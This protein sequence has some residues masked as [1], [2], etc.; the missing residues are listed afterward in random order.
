VVRGNFS[1]FEHH[2]AAP[3]LGEY[4][5]EAE[6]AGPQ[7]TKRAERIAKFHNLQENSV[8]QRS[9]I[10]KAP[11]LRQ[12]KTV[13]QPID[14]TGRDDSG[15]GCPR[16]NAASTALQGGPKVRPN[17]PL[18]VDPEHSLKYRRGTRMAKLHLKT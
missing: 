17:R 9:R 2:Y 13:K 4:A 6:P 7:P 15:E 11:C 3:L 10:A 14:C 18:H 12:D 1:L 16:Q 5:A 8:S